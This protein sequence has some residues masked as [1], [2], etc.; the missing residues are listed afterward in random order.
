MKKVA[1]RNMGCK[2]NT[3]EGEVIKQLLKDEFTLVPWTAQADYYV[4]NTCSVTSRADSRARN[5][6]RSAKRRNPESRVLVTGCYAQTHS[7][8]IAGMP[9]VTA[10]IGNLAK[11]T[12]IPSLIDRLESGDPFD[13]VSVSNIW[14]SDTLDVPVIEAYPGLARPYVKIQDGCN[15]I[16]SFCKIPQAR[17]RNRSQPLDRIVDQIER[18]ASAGFTEVVFAGVHMGCYG[19]DLDPETGLE[20]LLRNV[21]AIDPKLRV[22]LSS[23]EPNHTTYEL[24]DYFESE[25]RV[26]RHFHLPMQSGQD[27]ILARM[28]RRYT[29]S[30]YREKVL[31]LVERMP[32]AAVGADVIIGFPGETA[33]QFR[34]T[35]D[36]IADLPVSYLHVF[37]YSQR[38]KTAA[39]KMPDQVDGLEKARRSQILRELSD[40]KWKAFR[41]GQLGRSL[42]GTVIG[43]VQ[44]SVPGFDRSTW[45]RVLTTN[46]IDVL[47]PD[48]NL[49]RSKPV[50]IRADQLTDDGALGTLLEGASSLRPKVVAMR[51]EN[52]TTLSPA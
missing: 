18:F 38:D 47:I 23:I 31:G 24:L 37:P 44:E 43:M 10:V 4:L 9:E 14:S 22:R 39:A 35:C 1:V 7:D 27:E 36:F 49:E 6:I 11:E 26:C 29:S 25:P 3:H 17:G 33:E 46:Y 15:E 12:E 34:E 28:R 51:D 52:A 13:K 16:C 40:K 30:H 45:S 8:D 50:T 32:H 48:S 41:Q 19:E 5:Y 42:E 2:L 20:D 21:L